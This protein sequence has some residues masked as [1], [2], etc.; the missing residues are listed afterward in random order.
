[1]SQKYT[2]FSVLA[3]LLVCTLAGTPLY[4]QTSFGRIS[5]TV[6]DGSGAPVAGV[7]VA[8]RNQETQSI[9]SAETDANGYYVVTNLPIG[10]YVVEVSL[11]GFQPQKLTGV[12]VVAD[13]RLTADFKLTVSDLSQSIEVVS[14]AGE[15]LNTTSGEL[16][17]VIET[18][19][20]ENLALNG[21]NYF[22]L[23]TLVPGAASPNPTHS[24]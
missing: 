10:P 16:S 7:I 8:V 13:G 21:G 14:Q 23:M 9:R 4:S 12:N 17:R 20:V 24:T 5:G 2:F 1:M 11:K 3:A 19:Q 15:T 6:T 22:Q 18:N